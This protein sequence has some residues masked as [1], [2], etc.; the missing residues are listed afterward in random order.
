MDLSSM[1]F[2]GYKSGFVALVGKPNVGKSTLL[3][4]YIGQTVAAV[5]SK[6]QTT[7]KRQLIILTSETAQVIFVD[8]PGLHS[9]RYKLSEF[10][11]QEARYALNDADLILFIA[12]V[13]SE[14]DEED[15]R[16][17]QEIKDKVIKSPVVLVL[18]KVDLVSE[19]LL[20]QRKTKYEKLLDFVGQID[21]SAITSAGRDAL[22]EYVIQLLPEGPMY[23]PEEQITD[24]YERE[25]AADLIRAAA[26][27]TLRDEIPYGIYVRMD[28]YKVREND[29]LYVHATVMVERESHKGM[30]IGKG[31]VMIKEISTIARQ[32][33]EEMSGKS[34]FL[35]LKV[36]V[37]KNWRN[38]PQF[39]V[40]YGLTHG[41]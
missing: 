30:V 3:N 34:V 2:K 25:I 36:K 22:L 19:E 28:D 31:G 5:S 26:L 8:T 32:E 6:P 16:L 7:R 38:N 24:T 39:L 33:I 35:E 14:P 10:I 11:N 13:S 18:N 21:V 20:N 29:M 41:K 23:Y 4:K 15:Q 1:D 9:G 12:D 17:A 40:R 37:E 27:T